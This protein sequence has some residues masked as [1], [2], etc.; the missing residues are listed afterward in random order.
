MAS[1]GS[2]RSDF[3]SGR[4][5]PAYRLLDNLSGVLLAFVVVFAPWAFGSTVRWAITTSCV[6]AY[7]MGALLLGKWMLRWRM[8]FTPPR[9]DPATGSKWP[10]RWLAGLT[11]VFLAYCLT[12]AINYH[13]T[14]TYVDGELQLDYRDSIPWLPH[15]FDA[16]RSWRAFHRYAALAC[17]FWASRD[18]LLGKSRKERR[19]SRDDD[20]FG[21]DSTPLLPERLRV[22]L[23]IFCAS[24][25]AMA[26]MALLQRF[27]GTGKLLWLIESKES[28]PND[29]SFGPFSYRANG[30]QYF[31]LAW[32]VC[33]GFWWTLRQEDRRVRDRTVRA[34]SQS[35]VM[36]IPCL[37]FICT[38]PIASTSRG[39]AIMF[40]ITLAATLL[41]LLW[42]LRR[43][44]LAWFA[45]VGLFAASLG[46]AFVVGG[47]RL[48]ERFE[49]VFSDKMSGRPAIYEVAR[50]M[51]KDYPVFGTGAETFVS[52]YPLYRK[53]AEDV[54]QGYAHDD[55]L[56][57]RVTLGWV[58]LSILVAALLAIP[59]NWAAG[60]GVAG[61]QEFACMLLIA[62][63]GMLVHAKFDFP[64]QIF[65]LLT[66][67]LLLS[68]VATCLRRA[69]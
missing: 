41:V 37:V 4:T 11:V 27:D 20:E 18:W 66:V 68:A 26:L 62:L 17:L 6:V 35:H 42:T 28:N 22:F 50:A 2:A 36:L 67:F 54:R 19:G 46:L 57:T 5:P 55:W 53:G 33:L 60:R 47:E 45:I 23:W 3:A 49:T 52:L 32:P 56:E 69:R 48:R 12:G 10:I 13:A 61:S 64:F 16:P 44:L 1:R 65:S 29:F 7:V 8:D 59:L 63:G 30:A 39:G 21:E 40:G 31:N 25:A 43:K 24:S 51:A 15:S 14:G 38:G 34:G 9:W 58:G